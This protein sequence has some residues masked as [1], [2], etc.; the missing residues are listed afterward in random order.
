[1]GFWS[2]NGTSRD[3]SDDFW[4][5]A[6]YHLCSQAGRWD[7]SSQTWVQDDIDCPCVDAGD[8]DWDWTGEI[9]PHGDRINMGAYGGTPQAS[10]SL[11]AE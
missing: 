3:P 6:D 10:M 8:P 1:M 2:K 9:W 5:R 7:P 11:S 4:V